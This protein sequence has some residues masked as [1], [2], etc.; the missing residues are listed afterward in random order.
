MKLKT[1]PIC[2]EVWLYISDGDY[3]SG[4]EAKGFRMSCKCHYAWNKTDWCKTRKEAIDA[5]NGRV[6]NE[7]K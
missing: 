3:Y 7:E 5:W 4:Y 2:G 6:N 1:C